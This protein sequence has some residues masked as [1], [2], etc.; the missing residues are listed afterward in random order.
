MGAFFAFNEIIGR[1]RS[2]MN[3][4]RI[5]QIAG[6]LAAS[7]DAN[8]QEALKLAFGDWESFLAPLITEENPTEPVGKP[9]ALFSQLAG[10]PLTD[11]E[12]GWV[13]HLRTFYKTKKFL[14][15][16][17]ARSLSDIIAKYRS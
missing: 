3:S 12:Q 16:K 2:E 5:K 14:S 15:A 6:L 11:S 8:T 10:L 1:K 4:R 9:A 13:E 17:Q 7:T